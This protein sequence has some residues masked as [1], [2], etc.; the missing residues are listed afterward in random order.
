LENRATEFITFS[1]QVEMLAQH[2]DRLEAAL[3]AVE[4]AQD[5]NRIFSNKNTLRLLAGGAVCVA[6]IFFFVAPVLILLFAGIAGAAVFWGRNR[7]ATSLADFTR[8]HKIFRRLCEKFLQP[9]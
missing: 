6:V 2:G 3:D 7:R 8:Q 1:R 9:G 5:I 4:Q